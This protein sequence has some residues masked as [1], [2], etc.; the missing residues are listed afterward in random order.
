MPD[1]DPFAARAREVARPTPVPGGPADYPLHHT[2]VTVDVA[3]SARLTD[4]QQLC[5]RR[6]LY[7]AVHRTFAEAGIAWDR[8]VAEDRG[9][10]VLVVVPA[11]TPTA[12]VLC[13]MSLPFAGALEAANAETAGGRIAVRVALHAGN[14]HR[15][16]HG[17]AGAAVNTAFRLLDAKPLREAL[18]ATLANVA[19][20]VS[21]SVYGDT[22]A[23]GYQGIDPRAFSPVRV[24]IKETDTRGWVHVP[25]RWP[26]FPSLAPTR[27]PARRRAL[28]AVVAALVVVGGAVIG[29][30]IGG[31]D[32][33]GAGAG[34]AAPSEEVPA[35]PTSVSTVPGMIPPSEV[36]AVVPVPPA[37]AEAVPPVPAQTEASRPQEEQDEP[38]V[39][40]SGAVRELGSV[41]GI[42]FD[43]GEVVAQDIPGADMSP[44]GEGNHMYAMS[45]GTPDLAL[46]PDTGPEQYQRCAGLD[47]AAWI[48]HIRDVYQLRAG[49]NICVRT[50][51]GRI[52]MFTLDRVPSSGLQTMDLHYLVWQ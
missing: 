36:P 16:V 22:V 18:D 47:P 50:D 7:A 12:L 43:I 21:D 38:A 30:S 24:V 3:R 41:D 48:N 2:I 6:R 26:P 17:H 4:P 49:A 51:E 45:H 46:L 14:V 9:D 35:G 19:V 10:G 31:V 44:G 52:A 40:R 13:A 20:I 11:E 27:R 8:C 33:N 32:R 23:H 28:T 42:D 25:G 5:V 29:L 1:A 37:P 39:A 34:V 15:D